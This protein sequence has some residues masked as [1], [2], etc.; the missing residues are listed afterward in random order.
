MVMSA[1]PAGGAFQVASA[2][3]RLSIMALAAGFTASSRL[4]FRSYRSPSPESWPGLSPPSTPCLLTLSK[5]DVD[6]RDKRGHDGGE[7]VRS[8]RN[9]APIC[10]PARSNRLQA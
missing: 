3:T 4:V 7:G 5:K 1:A 9:K 2:T 10:L 6:A 8:H